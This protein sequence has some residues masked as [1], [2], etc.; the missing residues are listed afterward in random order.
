MNLPSIS[1][2]TPSLNQGEYIEETIKSVLDQ[3]YPNLEYRVMDGGS[4]DDSVKI[5]R[6]YEGR[7]TGWASAPD[8]GQADAIARGFDLCRGEIFGYLNSDD[9][10]LPGTLLAVAKAFEANRGAE[11]IYGDVVMIDA[12]GKPL[13]LDV[14]PA[15]N[16]QDLRRVCMI[17]QQGA[18]WRRTAYEGVDG[19]NTLL[20]FA[21]DY[22]LFLRIAERG[23]V[24]H[25]SRLMAKF[26]RHAEA[27]TSKQR[28][29][30]MREEAGLHEK[31]LGR[32]GWNRADWLRMKWLTLRQIGEIA[33]R[34]LKGEK[35]PCLTPARW[36][37]IAKRKVQA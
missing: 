33:G 25:L 9:V 4:T 21:F 18:F 34:R 23:N 26:R 29:T 19:I 37:R 13:A 5:I 3:G 27:K 14:L 24:R 2:I 11:L 35:F 36:E 8:K 12:Q 17:P 32:S 31:Y 16:W 1:I 22:D 6:R 20:Q 10:Y 7:L 15:Y 28:E 30:W